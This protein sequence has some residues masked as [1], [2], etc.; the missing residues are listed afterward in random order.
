LAAKASPTCILRVELLEIEPLI[1]RRVRVM[2]NVKLKRLHDILQIVLGWEDSHLHEF[3]AG[4]LIL[5]M[6]E[7]DELDA[8]ENLQDENEWSLNEVLETGVTEFEYLYDFGDGWTH[9]II[10]EPA[11]RGGE[12]GPSPLCLAGENACPPEDV[13]GPHRYAEFLSAMVDPLHEQH[14]DLLRWIGGVW[15]PRGFDL[16]RAN[17]DL[18]QPRRRKP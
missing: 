9:R 4:K 17:R 5:G 13:G 6:K 14:R 7:V 3:R 8:R 2:R 12:P 1:W 18:R 11:T 16:N 15:D 10:V